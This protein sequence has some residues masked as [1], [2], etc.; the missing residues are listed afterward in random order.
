M[1]L[2]GW[3]RGISLLFPHYYSPYTVL[4]LSCLCRFIYKAELLFELVFESRSRYAFSEDSHINMRDSA[5]DFELP[6]N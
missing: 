6:I 4:H 2:H 3:L 1:G 5:F